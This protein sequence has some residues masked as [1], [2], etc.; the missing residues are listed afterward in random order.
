MNRMDFTIPEF[1][2]IIWAPGSH[3]WPM[4]VQAI[5]RAWSQIERMTVAQGMRTGALQTV[6][7]AEL[8]GLQEY[9]LN[10]GIRFVI[11]GREGTHAVYGNA[12]SSYEEGRPWAYKVYLGGEPEDFLAAW[13][14]GNNVVI[15]HHLGYPDCCVTSF[16]NHWKDDGWRDTTPFMGTEG[17]YLCNILLRHLGVRSVFHLP[18]RFTCVPTQMLAQ[19][20]LKAASFGFPQEVEWIHD[21]L[22]WPISW[23][24]LHGVAIVTTPYVKIVSSTDPLEEELKIKLN[25]GG[26]QNEVIPIVKDTWSANGFQ[27]LRAM[28]L[29]HDFILKI[30]KTLN[31]STGP[32]LD[33]GAGNGL[34]LQRIVEGRDY[35]KPVGIDSLIENANG[36]VVLG[37]IHDYH[38][39]NYDTKCSLILMSINRL[40][41]TD[42]FASYELLEHIKDRTRLFLLYSYG[43]WTH[44]F[45]E[46]INHHF[47]VVT[48]YEDRKFNHQA[49]LLSP[50]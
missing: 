27:S 3:S 20:I 30:T 36:C 18:C 23:S 14:E 26:N 19:R 45:D 16:D 13:K 43:D 22:R 34:L 5:N 7:P 38:L 10:N 46:K 9:C 24:S 28:N 1:T 32:V 2:R 29:S 39:W 41:E 31:L 48:R 8:M 49:I 37:D 4:R 33:L 40:I 25:Q 44:D 12:T 42:S 50:R 47:Y 15:G 11:L 17:S 35:L 21:I 6:N